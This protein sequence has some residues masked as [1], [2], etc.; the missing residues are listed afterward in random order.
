[1]QKLLTWLQQRISMGTLLLILGSVLLLAC[2]MNPTAF[3]RLTPFWNEPVYPPLLVEAD[4]AF[5]QGDYAQADSLLSVYDQ[6]SPPHKRG[7]LRYRQLLALESKFLH[8]HSSVD[9][10][11]LADTLHN[12]FK[13]RSHEKNAKALAIIG[14]IYQVGADYPSALSY[15]LKAEEEAEKDYPSL[16]WLQGIIFRMKGDIYFYQR[17]FDEMIPN[18]QTSYN[19]TIATKDTL[20]MAYA[21]IRMGK[22]STYLHNID[23]IIYYYQKAIELG[24]SLEQA[25]LIVPTS[26][27]EL[28]DMYLQTEEFEKAAAIM[29]HDSLNTVNWAYWHYQQNH[30]DSAIYYFQK[31][32]YK[33]ND[34]AD[35]EFLNIL[36][37][38]EMKK[39]N[40]S[41]ANTYLSKCNEAKD[42]FIVN[43]QKEAT[44]RT[45]AQ[46]NLNTTKKL[47]ERSELR[48]RYWEWGLGIVVILAILAS[49]YARFEWKRQQ[50]EKE[51]TIAREQQLRQEETRQHRQSLQQIEE[52]NQ[53][54]SELERQLEEVRQQGKQSQVKQLE[55]DT[56]QLRTANANIKA[57]N[58][59]K[60]HLL[61]EF[62][63]TDLFKRI[64]LNS[65]RQ[66]F[67]LHDEEWEELVH[68]IDK[69]YDNFTDRLLA[70]TPMNI[71]EKRIC[72]LV[73]IGLKPVQIALILCISSTAISMSRSRLYNKIFHEKGSAKDFNEFILRF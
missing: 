29:P 66:D 37:D 39:G 36:A 38:L 20:R 13:V 5:R 31:A 33:D 41:L 62:Q 32:L 22:V 1:M 48:S 14:D 19:F 71:T 47:L 56:E 7:I 42:S 55:L 51:I 70:L 15:Y 10:L 57:N 23:S 54:I 17:M 46:F 25:E 73:K 61:Q 27:C 4:S 11:L 65:G 28:A 26:R 60:E 12:Y 44:Q 35:A 34:Y 49:I 2:A 58:E 50:R 69:I 59:R 40:V 18:Y 63:E 68:W 45:E 3:M 24:S 52:N 16:L 53:R 8:G 21:A 67:R 72:Y 6:A 30:V 9:D 64:R 43:S